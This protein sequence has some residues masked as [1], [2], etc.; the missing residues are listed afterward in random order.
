MAFNPLD[1]NLPNEEENICII[2][3]DSLNSAQTY[4]LP[5]CKH[6]FHTHCIITWFRHRA[7]YELSLDGCRKN[8]VDGK[9]PLCGNTGI[10]NVSLPATASMSYYKRCGF[11]TIRE[12]H[13]F[14]INMKE[15]KKKDAPPLIKRYIKKLDDVQKKYNTFKEEERVFKK[16]LKSEEVN[17]GETKK[18]IVDYSRKLWKLRGQITK[19]KKDIAAFHIVPLIIPMPIDIN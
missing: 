8:E 6:K 5:E 4:T 14:S 10:N 1:V 15:G 13:N 9:C 11:L 16:S 7:C 2:C 3:H 19:I 18:K 17:Y 12:K